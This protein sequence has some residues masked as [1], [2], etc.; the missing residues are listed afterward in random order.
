MSLA[1]TPDGNP[2][3]HVNLAETADALSLLREPDCA[4]VLWQR[5]A[6]PELSTWINGLDP[7]QL[8]EG[9]VI[10]RPES[11]AAVAGQLCDEAQMPAGP[12]RAQLIGEINALAEGFSALMGAA[13]LRLRLNVVSTNSCRKFHIDAVSARLICTFR[14]TG[15][16]YG[17]ATADGEPAEI[18][19][20]PTG[21]PI[22]LKGTLW[23]TQSV[24]R[25]LH[26]SPPIDGTGET[27]LLLV[28][29]PLDRPVDDHL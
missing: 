17:M 22:L 12:E 14:G 23:P 28:L 1:P 9:R 18:F 5:P 2:G 27:R 7:E 6:L 20:A 8:P 19:T 16:Q 11:V 15:T 25:L 10:V 21:A 3:A 13:Y 26:R 29:D 24:D 4:A